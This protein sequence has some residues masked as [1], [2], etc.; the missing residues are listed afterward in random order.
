MRGLEGGGEEGRDRGANINRWA[1]ALFLKS[2][3]V[4]F[5]DFWNFPKHLWECDADR[6]T[7]EM[8]AGVRMLLKKRVSHKI[9]RHIAH[10]HFMFFTE[11]ITDQKSILIMFQFT[12]SVRVEL[13]IVCPGLSLPQRP[14]SW[15]EP[16]AK[17]S[18]A[19]R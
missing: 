1:N 3:L 16:L 2:R 5:Q 15:V 18:K 10:L 9:Q 6:S 7:M 12:E 17:M 19:N 4:A 13:V 14:A 11:P 8:S